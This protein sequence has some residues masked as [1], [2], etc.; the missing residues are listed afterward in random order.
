MLIYLRRFIPDLFVFKAKIVKRVVLQLPA[1]TYP[2]LKFLIAY[3]PLVL[4]LAMV[5]NLVL[6]L[7]G[8]KIERRFTLDYAIFLTTI[9]LLKFLAL[10]NPG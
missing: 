1:R 7:Q 9:F 6:N 2:V 3:L 8:Y 4:H 5:R 10:Q